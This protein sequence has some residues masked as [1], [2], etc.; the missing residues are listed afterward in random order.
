[1]DTGARHHLQGT[2]KTRSCLTG[3][4]AY[5]WLIGDYEVLCGYH[6]NNVYATYMALIGTSGEV[7]QIKGEVKGSK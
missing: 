3:Y 2:I 6:M 5:Y 7:E 4:P 1:M